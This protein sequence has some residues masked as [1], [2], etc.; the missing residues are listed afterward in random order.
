MTKMP[1]LDKGSGM[2]NILSTKGTKPVASSDNGS[3]NTV[4]KQ[5]SQAG[6]QDSGSVGKTEAS[7][8]SEA[9]G[10]I[11]DTAAKDKLNQRSKAEEKTKEPE[12]EAKAEGTGDITEDTEVLEKAGG[13]MVAALAAQ[14]GITE[15]ALRAA[16]D[17]LGMTDVS[18]LDP[19]NVKSLMVELTEGADDMSLL[20]DEDFYN[21]VTEALNTLEDITGEVQKETGMSPEDF[22]M[23]VTA[24]EEQLAASGKVQETAGE[25]KLSESEEEPISDVRFNTPKPELTEHARTETAVPKETSK[26]DNT[27]KNSENPFMQNGYQTQNLGQQTEAL[28]A[29]QTESAFSIRDTQEIMDQILDYM[30]VSVK[31]GLSSLEMQLHPESLGTLHI[32]ISN[33][34]GAVTAQFIAQNESVRAALESQV[35]ELKENLEQQGVK[36]EAVEVTIAQYSLDRN[37]DGSETAADQGGRQKKGSR[38][39]NLSELNLDEEEDLTE[40]ERLTAEMMQSEGSTINYTA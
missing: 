9:K 14:M 2:Q 4:L 37:P 11:E 39:L 22:K 32:Q 19:A 27:G 38:N 13:E 16:M 26:Q 7:K 36:V 18:L 15:D 35:M 1:V 6:K 5:T 8:T 34:E 31:P 33:R 21:S 40:E 3:F 29:A 24:A 17:D 30:K 28:R 20:M 23:A 10:K 12:T 25:E